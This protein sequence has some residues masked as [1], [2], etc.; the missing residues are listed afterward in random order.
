MLEDRSASDGEF[1][2]RFIADGEPGNVD[3][4]RISSLLLAYR[5]N[6]T[7]TLEILQQRHTRPVA[8]LSIRAGQFHHLKVEIA[9][10]HW[11][12]QL[13]DQ[14]YE[15][16]DARLPSERFYIQ[17]YGWQ[18]TDRWHVRNFQVY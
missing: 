2:L 4:T 16:N 6:G 18:P 7:D 12:I 10:N 15:V 5:R 1:Q 14:Q 3:P 11:R 8:D 13:D 9:N 17:L